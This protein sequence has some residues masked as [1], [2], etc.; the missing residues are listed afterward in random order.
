MPAAVAVFTPLSASSITIQF[1]GRE[2]S[3]H[4]TDR[5]LL[6]YQKSAPSGTLFICNND[7]VREVDYRW[8]HLYASLMHMYEKLTRI[9]DFEPYVDTK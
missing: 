1:A 5:I 4:A 8:N 7:L 2:D 3:N 6:T 9:P